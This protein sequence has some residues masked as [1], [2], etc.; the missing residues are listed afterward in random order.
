MKIFIDRRG[1]QHPFNIAKIAE[2]V[3]RAAKGVNVT[4]SGTDIAAMITYKLPDGYVYIETVQDAVIDYLMLHHEVVG[5]AYETYAK[6]HAVLRNTY[7][8]TSKTVNEYLDESDWRV[9]ANANV[10]FSMGGLSGNIS[11]KVIANYWLNEIYSKETGLAHR[12]GDFHIHDLDMLSGYCAGWSLQ[13]L[14]LE[15][16]NGVDGDIESDPPLHLSSAIS[17]MLNFLCSLQS[18]WAGAQAFSSFDTLL[19]PFIRNDNMDRQSVKQCLQNFIYTSN[20]NS[21]GNQPVFSNISFDIDCPDD[22]ANKSPIIGDKVLDYT[23]S[24]LK[25][26]SDMIRDVFFGIMEAGDAKGNPFTFPVTN[27]SITKDFDWD[28]P[29]SETMFAASAKYGVG[30]FSNFINSDMSPNQIR[31]MC[32]RLRLDLTK[33]VKVGGGLFGQGDQTGSVGVVTINCARLGYVCNGKADLFDKLDVLLEL[34][35]DALVVKRASITALLDG[36]PPAFMEKFKNFVGAADLPRSTLYP[37]TKRY[38]GKR[39]FTTFFSTIGVNG[40][41]EMILNFTHGEFDITTD[42]GKAL[43]IELLE[44]CLAKLAEF[45]NDTGNLFN[46]E[47]TPAEGA[48]HRFA[49]VDKEKYPDIIQAGTP[50]APYYTNSTQTHVNWSSDPW[51]VLEHQDDL[52]TL[53]TSGTILH[54]YTG[55]D[56]TASQVKSIVKK[57]FTYFKLPY[58]TISP[59]FTICPA[60]GYIVG[61]HEDCTHAKCDEHVKIWTRTMGYHRPVESFNDGKA[62]EFKERKLFQL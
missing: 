54:L 44:H 53:Y 60:H 27:S 43:A 58:L 56:L 1:N 49:R 59:V 30:T 14:L 23:Y 55:Q 46:L 4:I 37:Y 7:I 12:N 52:Q 24:D 61:P 13:N 8:D 39:G 45:Q 20:M 18:E 25:Y 21:R 40:V 62:S 35:K 16:F 48:T 28:S 5:R 38:L 33:L 47:A 32:C 6:R 57:A 15:G 11:G 50:E 2:A 41:N 19:A 22:F 10:G 42:M 34:A 26:E 3:E 29:S 9:K 36:T 51:E 31:S 17:Q